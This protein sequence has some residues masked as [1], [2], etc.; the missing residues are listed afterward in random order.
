MLI[1][2]RY[3][4]Y[5]LGIATL[6]FLEIFINYPKSLIYSSGLY[7]VLLI[8]ALWYLQKGRLEGKREKAAFFIL[9]I[10][11][12]ANWVSFMVYFS[13]PRFFLHLLVILASAIIWLYTESFFLKRYFLSFYRRRSFEDL[14]ENLILVTAFLLYLNFFGFKVY[15]GWP[16]Y[17]LFIITAVA[18][19]LLIWLQLTF[20]CLLD[21]KKSLIYLI[22]IPVLSL[23]VIGVSIFLPTNFYSIALINT[24][25]FY[26][27]IIF[28]RY[29]LLEQ[30]SEKM[31]RK[32][33]L[34]GV[35]IFLFTIFISNWT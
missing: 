32:Y 7:I 26:V 19:F 25:L 24:L 31:A 23:E 20:N 29:H 33:L 15:I 30:L 28:S 13:F 18:L 2:K 9:P 22:I 4:S 16:Y 12:M 6:I 34:L 21:K 3:L 27:F 1:I 14:T 8:F 5:F 11:F 17:T 35:I 10:L